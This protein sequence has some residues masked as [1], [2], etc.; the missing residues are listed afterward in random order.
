MMN[1]QR[2]SWVLGLLVTVV[3]YSGRNQLQTLEVGSQIDLRSKISFNL[4]QLDDEGLYGP[5]SGLRALDYEFCIPA[6]PVFEAQVK[7]IDPT[8]V[9]YAESK[10][11]I[12]CVPGEKLCLGHT[13]QPEF[14]AVLLK[15]AS[16]PFVKQI[17][18]CFFE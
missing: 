10:G 4:D 8:I 11:R 3:L 14:K 7:A 9:I 6:D 1:Y 2:L 17:K 12:G 13:H 16:L 5:P 18:Q 15:L